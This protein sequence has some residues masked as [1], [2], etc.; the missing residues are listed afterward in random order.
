M[1]RDLVWLPAQFT[2]TNDGQA[3]GLVPVRYP[4]SEQAATRMPVSWRAR[5]N[6][7][8]SVTSDFAGLGQRVLTTSGDELGLLD[9]REI[10]LDRR[11]TEAL[12]PISACASA[13][14]L[15]LLDRLID[16]ERLLTLF[17]LTTRAAELRRL[18]IARAGS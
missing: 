12:W 6:G 13:C 11:L 2:W 8:S 5:R 18:G 14:S 3:M 10:S 1:S 16:D 7:P 17:E 15:R 9:V 4:G